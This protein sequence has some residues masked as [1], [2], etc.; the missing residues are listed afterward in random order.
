[1]VS[2]KTDCWGETDF[3]L[4]FKMW[5]DENL[6]SNYSTSDNNN[7]LVNLMYVHKIF[8]N[9]TFHRHESVLHNEINRSSIIQ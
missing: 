2:L 3:S 4:V 8:T 5:Y 6:S 9:N 1:M 7:I